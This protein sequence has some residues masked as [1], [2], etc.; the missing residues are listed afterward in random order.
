MALALRKHLMAGQGLQP[1]SQDQLTR[2]CAA[3]EMGSCKSPT[4]LTTAS[5]ET[6]SETIASKMRW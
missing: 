3:P 4:S 6:K 2:P 5:N 1:I